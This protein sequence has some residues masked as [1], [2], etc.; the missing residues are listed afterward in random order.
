MIITFIQNATLIVIQL[1]N[2]GFIIFGVYIMILFAKAL[3]IY[4]RNNE[5]R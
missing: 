4:I 5:K 1:I 3:K 2:F